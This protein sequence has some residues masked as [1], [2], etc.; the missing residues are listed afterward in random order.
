VPGVALCLW[1]V[2]CASQ[3]GNVLAYGTQVKSAELRS[4]AFAFAGKRNNYSIC[5]ASKTGI[6]NAF[7][8]SLGGKNHTQD[9]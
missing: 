7:L 3:Q 4:A 5:F 6:A 9:G 1:S 8:T 2:P